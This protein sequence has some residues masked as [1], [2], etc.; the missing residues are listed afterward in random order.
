[1]PTD[2]KDTVNVALTA[3]Q[4]DRI[5]VWFQ[6]ALHDDPWL[7]QSDWDL[8]EILRDARKKLSE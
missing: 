3:E 4:I 6:A 2:A 8:S 5:L 1:M 7:A